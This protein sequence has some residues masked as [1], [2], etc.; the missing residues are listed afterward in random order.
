MAQCVVHA[1]K[2]LACRVRAML[3][4]AP[5]LLAHAEV[6]KKHKYFIQWVQNLGTPAGTSGC[7]Y[8]EKGCFGAELARVWR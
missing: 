4:A 8:T 7:M 6:T 3:A 5:V 2:G 1:L